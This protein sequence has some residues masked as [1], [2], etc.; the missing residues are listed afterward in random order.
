ME[1]PATPNLEQVPHELVE[2]GA[3]GRLVVVVGPG[4][5]LGTGLPSWKGLLDLLLD[6]ART[7]LPLTRHDELD[8]AAEWFR[9]DGEELL[10]ASLLRQLLGE[11]GLAAGIAGVLRRSVASPGP[12]HRALAELPGA[13]FLTTNYDA[14]LEAA[15]AERMNTPPAVVVLS[16]IDGLR[17]L[18]VGQVLK[19]HGDIDH[20]H[21][22]SI[23]LSSEDYLRTRNTAARA[24]KERLRTLVQAPSQFL[25][26][27]YGYGDSD[28]GPVLDEL[29]A[30]LGAV[31]PTPFWIDIDGLRQRAKA[32][33][34]GLRGVL[35]ASSDCIEPWLRA[36]ERAI[37]HSPPARKGGDAN[38]SYLRNPNWKPG[39]GSGEIHL[40]ATDKPTNLL[41][42]FHP[43]NN[44]GALEAYRNGQLAFETLCGLTDRHAAT[45]VTSFCDDTAGPGSFSPPIPIP[46]YQSS[47][48]D[49]P[50]KRFLVGELELLLLQKLGLLSELLKVLGGGGRLLVFSDVW[51]RIVESAVELQRGED[52]QPQAD[53]QLAA[54]LERSIK[55]GIANGLVDLIER[56]Q[57]P[58]LPL[59]RDTDPDLAG[60]TH[61]RTHLAR[62]LAYR[63][64]IAESS[65]RWLLVAD[66]RVTS[67]LG[68]EPQFLLRLAF[69]DGEHFTSLCERLDQASDRVVHLPRLVRS[70]LSESK[71][72][73]E[74]LYQLATLG[75]PDALVAAELV[76]FAGDFIRDEALPNRGS[77]MSLHSL[78]HALDGLERVARE[79]AHLGA[80]LARVCIA[81]TFARAT[82]E[83]FRDDSAE[84][85]AI[86]SLLLHR[87]EKVD[88]LTSGGLLELVIQ[89]AG[90][91]ALTKANFSFE[92]TTTD[93]QVVELS[94]ASPVGK[95]WACVAGWVGP[96]GTRR[97]AYGRAVRWIWM[98]MVEFSDLEGPPR[99][100]A[101][102]MILP[103]R[104]RRTTLMEPE[105]Q[106]PA[107]LSADW[108]HKPLARVWPGGAGEERSVERILEHGAALVSAD[109]DK[110]GF[111]EAHISYP[112][113]DGEVVVVP[114]E[115]VFL[116]VSRDAAV[117]FAR[118]LAWHQG[119][120][121]GRAYGLLQELATRPEDKLLRR[122][123][124][125]MTTT[126]PWRLVRE[127][128]TVI[129]SWV[130][131]RQLGEF[132]G[133]TE[134]LRKM[135]SEPPGALSAEASLFDILSARFEDGGA[136]HD[137]ADKWELC[138]QACGVP[139]VLP[140]IMLGLRLSLD[141]SQYGEEVTGALQRL[142]QPHAEPV[143]RLIGDIY[144]LRVA[145]VRRPYV[146]LPEGEI[147]LRE[148]LPERLVTVLGAVTSAPA[149]E[150][151]ET[152]AQ[153]EAGLLRLCGRVV[154]DLSLSQ[155]LS[156][157]DRLWLTYR[158]FQ[159]LVAQLDAMPPDARHAGLAAL[160]RISPPPAPF[161]EDTSDLLNPF[162]FDDGRLNHR[163]AAVL[164]AYSVMDELRTQLPDG[165]NDA[166]ETPR[167]V[168][169]S[170][171]EA[172][173]AEL[174]T[175]PLTDDERALR[176]RGDAP[177]CLDW[178]GSGAVPDLALKAL[179]QL[180]S[181]AFFGMPAE[182]RLRW[183][184]DMP[185][186]KA[187]GE[188]VSWSLA[189]DL[190]AVATNHAKN[191]SS[192]EKV[193]FEDYLR[194]LDMKDKLAPQADKWIWLGFTE[195][196]GAGAL[197]LEREVKD[198]LFDNLANAAAPAAFGSYLA[199]LSFVAADRLEAEADRVLAV[200][201]AIPKEHDGIDPVAFASGLARVIITGN[202]A[203]I[204][205]AQGIL[206]RLALRPPYE[207]EERMLRL[208]T[209]LRLS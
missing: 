176:A 128:P 144:F 83:A 201:E 73:N 104:A 181:E 152:F 31:L 129:S 47:R 187:V 175:R 69:R 170:A 18:T 51:W 209:L 145:A 43:L 41:L 110:V 85:E 68:D 2:A 199:A 26:V 97:A 108:V 200:V 115:A 122:D 7:I 149:L 30:A 99:H 198:L 86:A 98:K 173:L 172:V 147:D 143:T 203:S 5:N 119:P 118:D 114:V 62:T 166:K 42:N 67:K 56:P 165:P 23:V 127:D 186:N 202:P 146:V 167:A 171:L 57:I 95:F 22:K 101:A 177:S 90:G 124:A 193:A 174:A 91:F 82:W 13:T 19:L 49:L 154:S 140:A 66:Y 192:Q 182:V 55:A 160:R 58:D 121:D 12:I 158:L 162:Q 92:P 132:P 103:I 59:P 150:T 45:W 156:F 185:R 10:K 194:S 81:D 141:A 197:H 11:E 32:G 153:S 77:D 38:V 120:H 94:D 133:T 207:G 70:L 189:S 60:I 155:V 15:F 34:A 16:D 53:A 148:R 93:N 159:W 183:L 37:R 138:D 157:K 126:A 178:H 208:L 1:T 29:R 105:L 28:V 44:A 169:S 102:P 130:H 206:R 65:T 80:A 136:W 9:T 52:P 72:R 196:Y 14:L 109:P 48:L 180:H 195:L 8:E 54:D 112:S 190:V 40:A 135:L 17:R 75:F 24:W 96:D 35:L 25:F 33:A 79:P 50:G 39:Q 205:V 125:R 89:F 191:L 63:E 139:G 164:Y 123:Y 27:G 61:K 184:Q 3:S 76:D 100:A 20:K 4:A 161:S 137:R 74:L 163:L 71:H 117:T 116:R 168:T 188:R 64:A 204:P 78:P 151:F 111:N 36:L 134:H 113:F 21:P 87:A 142:D 107:T 106:A 131:R 84:R 88:S 46:S 6:H 179:L